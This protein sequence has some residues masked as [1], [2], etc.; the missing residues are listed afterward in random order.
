LSYQHAFLSDSEFILSL[1]LLFLGSHFEEEEKSD[2][3]EIP[4]TII[5]ESHDSSNLQY[6]GEDDLDEA[7]NRRSGYSKHVSTEVEDLD[8]SNMKGS[9]N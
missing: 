3:R 5:E 9:F 4:A 2:A 1:Y 8:K 7:P 6:R